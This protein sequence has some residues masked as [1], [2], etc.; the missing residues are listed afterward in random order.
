MADSVLNGFSAVDV[1]MINTKKNEPRNSAK[2]WPSKTLH[3]VLSVWV[4]FA[5][6]ILTYR[7]G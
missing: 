5:L 3:F 6:Y 1:S 2:N 7:L 4:D